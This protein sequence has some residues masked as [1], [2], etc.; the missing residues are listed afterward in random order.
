MSELRVDRAARVVSE[1]KVSLFSTIKPRKSLDMRSD[2]SV[3]DQQYGQL[4]M[5]RKRSV[6]PN[7]VNIKLDT[8]KMMLA[9]RHTSIANFSASAAGV[10]HGD[11]GQKK[12]AGNIKTT[13]VR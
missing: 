9:R 1:N 2:I 12:V 10:T 8:G 4:A 7:F 5:Q 13:K 11:L 6:G 3:V